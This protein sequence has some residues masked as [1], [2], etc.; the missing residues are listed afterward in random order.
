[1]LCRFKHERMSRGQFL[2]RAHGSVVRR[3]RWR[4]RSFAR[5]VGPVELCLAEEKSAVGCDPQRTTTLVQKL[6]GHALTPQ[7]WNDAI[8]E[9]RTCTSTK[10][11]ST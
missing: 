9:E 10:W 3:R 6:L 4:R 7:L 5:V 11:A 2:A 8:E 1:M